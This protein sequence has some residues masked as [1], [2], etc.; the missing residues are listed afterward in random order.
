M[1]IYEFTAGFPC[2]AQ[3]EEG[4]RTEGGLKGILVGLPMRLTLGDAI[5]INLVNGID[6]AFGGRSTIGLTKKVAEILTNPI[7]IEFVSSH[8]FPL[9]GGGPMI[10]DRSA[11]EEMMNANLRK[12]GVSQTVNQILVA[13]L[14]GR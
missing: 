6:L 4:R 8:D 1:R 7:G 3:I 2:F 11:Q 9:G 12:L 10:D 5:R 14:Q 13:G